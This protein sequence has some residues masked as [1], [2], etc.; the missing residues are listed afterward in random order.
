MIVSTVINRR[1]VSVAELFL[2][3]HGFV[4]VQVCARNDG[5]IPRP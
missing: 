2:L 5:H 3:V 1:L 4:L